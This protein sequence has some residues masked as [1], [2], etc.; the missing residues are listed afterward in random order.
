ML[1]NKFG[2][3]NLK[4]KSFICRTSDHFNVRMSFSYRNLFVEFEDLEKTVPP[5]NVNFLPVN[6]GPFRLHLE[7]C[8]PGLRGPW[9]S[10]SKH[11][12]PFPCRKLSFSS[13]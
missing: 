1:G 5:L 9:S 10:S 12:G 8:P 11:R 7:G 6:T 13:M 4:A 2:N 3:K